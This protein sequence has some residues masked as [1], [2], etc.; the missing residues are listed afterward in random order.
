MLVDGNTVISFHTY[1]GATY[2]SINDFTS[3]GDV[4]IARHEV[5]P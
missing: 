1:L 5:T 3:S 4:L 2:T